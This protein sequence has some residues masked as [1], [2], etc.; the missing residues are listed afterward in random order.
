MFF[1]PKVKEDPYN[2][3]ATEYSKVAMAFPVGLGIKYGLTP[4]WMMGLELGGRWV[5][6]D[7]L[8]AFTSQYSKAHDFYYI[9]SFQMIYKID[10]SR[11]GW[12]ILKFGNR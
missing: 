7:Y 4:D 12:P 10:T 5:T 9:V 3:T 1:W 8:D 2:R 6:T 11:E